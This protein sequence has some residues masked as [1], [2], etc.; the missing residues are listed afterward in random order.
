MVHFLLIEGAVRI[1]GTRRASNTVP[2]QQRYRICRGS[3]PRTIKPSNSFASF[4]LHWSVPP[5]HHTPWGLSSWLSD[6][7]TLTASSGY[8]DRSTWCTSTACLWPWRPAATHPRVFRYGPGQPTL[9]TVSWPTK[10]DLGYCM[11]PAWVLPGS[12]HMSKAT[13]GGGVCVCVCVGHKSS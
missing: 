11:G 9:M 4:N 7:S 13:R 3:D 2:H 10:Q 8:G 5:Y 1:R 12:C 6:R